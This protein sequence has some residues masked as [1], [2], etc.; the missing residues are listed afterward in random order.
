MALSR[1]V[2]ANK[3]TL[4]LG[5][6]R[7]RVVS[8]VAQ[9]EVIFLAWP[10]ASAMLGETIMGLVDTKLVGGLGAAALGG[11]GVAG[12]LLHLSYVTLLGLMRGVKVC[13][14]YAVGRGQPS[15]G[16]R[17]AQMGV[18]IGLLS[19]ACCVVMFQHLGFVLEAVHIGPDLIPHAQAFLKARAWGL[20]ATF[21]LTALIE[22][23]Q[24]IGDVRTPM[25][26]GLAGNV[27]NAGLAYA[28]IYG[29]FGLPALGVSGAGYGTSIVEVLQLTALLVMLWRTARHNRRQPGA[30]PSLQWRL[31]LRELL[32]VG[33]PTAAHFC[34]E[35]TAFVAFTAILGSLSDADVA[36]HQIA[37][38]INRLAFLFGAAIGEAACIMV[39]RALGAQR[40]DL[41][42]QAV[43]AAVKVAMLFMGICG[44]SFA[45]W[46]HLLAGVFTTDPEVV[47][48]VTR[49]LYIAAVWQMF[50]A[51]NIIMRA[52]LRGAK[53]VRAAAIIGITILWTCLPTSVYGLG[54]VAG[55][56]VVGGWFG[57]LFATCLSAAF[58]SRR[59][60]RGDWRS[61]FA[62]PPV[63]HQLLG[64]SG[65]VTVMNA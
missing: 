5:R 48:L 35:T 49:L 33:L 43:K 34:F 55:L 50:D 2:I 59:W 54:K 13:T 36:A 30:I 6:T 25:L 42:D 28:L 14:A 62:P 47:G 20:P 15:H 60:L 4:A 37:G 10:I 31:A 52:A 58:F 16:V 7:A 29:K 24:G 27:I 9:G 11:V 44:I 19:G 46:G 51:L 21:A 65:S 57:F 22:H 12:S 41:A 53:D 3:A 26:V 1:T 61:R 32:M 8:F 45:I 38:A 63:P 40:L 64:H 23:R 17:Y 39:G 18:A 56:G